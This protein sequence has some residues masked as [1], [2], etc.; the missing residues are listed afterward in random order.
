[1]HEIEELENPLR[2]RDV[3]ALEGRLEGLFRLRVGEYRL[4]LGFDT[5]NKKID[6]LFIEPRGK[7]Y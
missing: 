3:R 2:H 5:T 1:L 7:A 4:I 6:V